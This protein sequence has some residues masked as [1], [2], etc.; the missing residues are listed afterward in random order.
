[1]ATASVSTRTNKHMIE[2]AEE[3]K[4]LSYTIIKTVREM[5]D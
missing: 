1:M 4:K 2:V 3:L 5:E